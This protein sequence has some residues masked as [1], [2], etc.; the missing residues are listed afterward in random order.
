LS[1]GRGNG[2]KAKYGEQKHPEQDLQTAMHYGLSP[3]LDFDCRALG[4]LQGPAARKS[5]NDPTPMHAEDRSNIRI[6]RRATTNGHCP[7][8]LKLVFHFPRVKEPCQQD[9]HPLRAL[10]K[11]S[12]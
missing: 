6:A 1:V 12:R 2:G 4:P 10:G 9:F 7:L 11:P 8:I 5:L 3:N